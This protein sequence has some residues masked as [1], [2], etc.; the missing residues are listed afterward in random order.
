MTA[1][2]LIATAP[3]GLEAVVGHEVQA[4]G[5]APRV[6]NGRV[7]WAGDEAAIC[8][9]NLWLRSADRVLVKLGEFP[10][11]TFEDLFQGTRA[12]PWADWLAPDAHFVVGGRS[13]QSQLTSV[14]ACQAVVE[15]AVVESLRQRHRLEWFPKTGA[16]AAI[17]VSLLRDVATLTLDTTGPGLHKRGYRQRVG[18]APL[19]ETL[20]AALI[21]LARWYWDR[22]LYDPCCG[23][24]TI[25]IEAALLALNLAPGLHRRFDAEGWPRLPSALWARVREEAHDLA[26]YD[27]ELAIAGSDIDPAALELAAHAAR[28]AGVGQA[29]RFRQAPVAR[30][31]P[32]GEYGFLITNPPYGERLGEAEAVLA[33]YRELGE[34]ARTLPTW[35]VYVLTA[36]RA[37]T[38]AFGRPAPRNRKLFNGRIQCYY[39]QYP[40][41]R[42]PR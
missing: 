10:A 31:R 3:M 33:L 19:K 38:R 9:A 25:P 41:P 21:Q 6:E 13:H 32:Q 36:H 7:V 12:L 8:R 2:E 1:M 16:R 20:A 27:R 14:P 29:V 40:G 42:R 18:P 37:F 4:L 23:T 24:G 17:E 28:D 39:Y 5:Y 22:P 35:G 15:K 34:L 11:A 30:A 26:R